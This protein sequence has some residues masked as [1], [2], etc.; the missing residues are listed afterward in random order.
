MKPYE[1]NQTT[2]VV[3]NENGGL[4]EFYRIAD[5]LSKN[6]RIRFTE[7]FDDADNIEWHFKYRGN[8]LALQYN[9][10]NGVTLLSQPGKLQRIADKLIVKMKVRSA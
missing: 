2:P 5:V 4:Q 6:R 9:I 3:I 7:K 10:F 8:P 1:Y